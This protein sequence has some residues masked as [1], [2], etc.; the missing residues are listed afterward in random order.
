MTRSID[1]ITVAF[2]TACGSVAAPPPTSDLPDATPEPVETGRAVAVTGVVPTFVAVQDGD[3]AFATGA[4][5]HGDRFGVAMGCADGSVTIVHRTVE[6]GLEVASPCREDGPTVRLTVQVTGLDFFGEQVAVARTATGNGGRVLDGTFQFPTRPGPTDLIGVLLEAGTV[7][8]VL[9]VPA[10]DLRRDESIAIDFATQGIPFAAEGLTLSMTPSV[11]FDQLNIATDLLTANGEFVLAGR[12][13]FAATYPALPAALRRPGD[14]FRVTITAPRRFMSVTTA[15]PGRVD[16]VLRQRITAP[17]PEV[18]RAPGLHARF[19]F[20]P[21]AVEPGQRY[22][23][24]AQTGRGPAIHRWRVELSTAWIG[25][26]ANVAYELPDLAEVAGFSAEAFALFD[27][28]PI[29]WSVTLEERSATGDTEVFHS[30]AA[31]GLVGEFCGDAI[32]QQGEACDD[33]TDTPTCDSDCTRPVCGDGHLNPTTGETCDPPDDSSCGQ[34][35]I[36]L[37]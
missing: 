33:G 14:R 29:D 8:K 23:L 13:P 34:G 4:R 24:N 1:L 6:E 7:L 36:F 3:E 12:A 2:I 30:S 26:A 31:G 9:R 17:P 27:R 10:L 5:V 19:R 22:V 18:L 15:S 16:L 37:G 11:P 25:G 32:V 21:I 20:A 35:C 28:S